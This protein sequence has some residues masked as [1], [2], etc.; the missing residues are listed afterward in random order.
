[1]IVALSMEDIA[2]SKGAQ[3]D[4]AQ[5]SKLLGCPVVGIDGRKNRSTKT[6]KECLKNDGNIGHPVIYS[7]EIEKGLGELV[8]KLEHHNWL[9]NPRWLA[10]RLL[11]RDL[12]AREIAKEHPDI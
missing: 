3:I 9:D 4:H 6:L 10:I 1:M 12:C 7:A 2:K 11:E 8:Q 5:L